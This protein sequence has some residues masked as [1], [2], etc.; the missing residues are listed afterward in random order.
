MSDETQWGLRSN[1][2]KGLIHVIPM[3]TFPLI[4]KKG[5]HDL[6]MFKKCNNKWSIKI[7]APFYI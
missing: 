2:K 7:E 1:H 3:E 4:G 6:K 5:I